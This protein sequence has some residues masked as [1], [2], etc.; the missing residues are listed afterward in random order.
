[1]AGS[2]Q[3]PHI[4]LVCGSDYVHPVRWDGSDGAAAWVQL[5]CGSC[6][7]WR[8][9]VF[10][11]AALEDFDEKLTRDESCMAVDADLLQRECWMAEARAFAIAL[12]RDLIDAGDFAR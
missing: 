6:E 4:C 3:P 5:R 9:D 11:A 1:M 2:P 7:T 8:E 12:D 10:D